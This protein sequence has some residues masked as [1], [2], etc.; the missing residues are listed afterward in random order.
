MRQGELP[1]HRFYEL[2][3]VARI[4]YLRNHIADEQRIRQEAG[5]DFDVQLVVTGEIVK[6]NIIAVVAADEFKHEIIGCLL[7]IAHKLRELF[8]IAED[9]VDFIKSN[10]GPQGQI[11]FYAFFAENR[12]TDEMAG[13][14]VVVVVILLETDDLRVGMVNRPARHVSVVA[15]E[16]DGAAAEAFHGL[17]LTPFFQAEANEAD[18]IVRV[19]GR[20]I[21]V[22][23]VCFDNQ[24]LPGV[25]Q[26]GVGVFQ[27][28]HMAL[29]VHDVFQMGYVAEGAVRFVAV[30][31]IG[32]RFPYV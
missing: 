30:D 16:N 9:E 13:L 22:A 23:V 12:R 11:D 15:V 21:A 32:L 6:E 29:G 10:D 25:L 2:F 5:H 14:D 7:H 27:P 31:R 3:S 28:N 8:L 4:G 19:V 24:G 20:K 18:G 17:D 26:D 1:F